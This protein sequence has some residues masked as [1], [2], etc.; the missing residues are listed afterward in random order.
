ML[1]RLQQD[2]NLPYHFAEGTLYLDPDIIDLTMIPPPIT[3]DNVNHIFYYLNI[4]NVV[5]G[6][7]QMALSFLDS[8]SSPP[9][10]FADQ[11]PPLDRHYLP[12]TN[13]EWDQDMLDELLDS[14][15]DLDEFLATVVV[16]APMQSGICELTP[17]EV[18]AFIIPPPPP[19]STYN[20]LVSSN[21]STFS[22][23]GYL[24]YGRGRLLRLF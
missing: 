23:L 16:Q 22:L 20:V 21:L 10:P 11:L 2:T 5:F 24:S 7:T 18:S 9:T 1:L 12:N 8:P 19:P 3:P 15:L 6:P 4:F 14:S 13:M 17:E